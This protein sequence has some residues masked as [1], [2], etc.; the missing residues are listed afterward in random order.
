MMRGGVWAA[1]ACAAAVEAAGWA[2]TVVAVE[3]GDTEADGELKPMDLPAHG[4]AMVA[5][6]AAAGVAAAVAGELK[7]ME[8]ERCKEV[9]EVSGGAGVAPAGVL[10]L[11]K[12]RTFFHK[13]NQQQTV[14]LSLLSSEKTKQT[15]NDQKKIKS[16]FPK[17]KIR[18]LLLP[19]TTPKIP[20]KLQKILPH[21]TIFF[22]K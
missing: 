15:K 22:Y 4:E 2:A 13:K 18:I 20:Q 6:M 17:K 3:T 21:T 14:V 19:K 10:L 9:P 8:V 11:T 16:N 5:D 7:A 1:G 12:K